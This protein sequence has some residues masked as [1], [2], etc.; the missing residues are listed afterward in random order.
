M[1]ALWLLL[2]PVAAA[3]CSWLVLALAGRAFGAAAHRKS[4]REQAAL[5]NFPRQPDRRT[6]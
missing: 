4:R 5:A 2:S 1:S 6:T 3:A